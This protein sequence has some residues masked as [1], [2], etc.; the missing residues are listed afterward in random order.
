M[1][2]RPP[3]ERE[4]LCFGGAQPE[5]GGLW[6]QVAPRA[7]VAEGCRPPGHLWGFYR[8]GHRVTGEG[9]SDTP[10]FPCGRPWDS[11]SD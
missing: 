8:W 9:H 3:R 2:K 5:A 6:G 11:S 1:A 10:E 7:V 4:L